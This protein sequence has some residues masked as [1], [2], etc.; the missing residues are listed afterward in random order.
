MIYLSRQ[1]CENIGERVFR[2]YEK[3]PDLRKSTIYRVNPE[4][5]VREVLKLKLEYHHLSLNGSV[6]G[7]TTPYNGIEYKIFD[8]EDKEDFYYFDG[9]TILIE[10]DLKEDVSKSGR[11]NFTT[12]HEAGHQILKMM[13]PKEYG[14]NYKKLHFCMAQPNRRTEKDWEEWQANNIGSVVIM[15][16]KLIG[17]AMFIF[18][19]GEKIEMINRI[20]ASEEYERFSGMAAF[21]GVSKK[22]LSIRLNQLGLV[23]RDYFDNPYALT[24][25]FFY[26]G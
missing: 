2:A 8:Y 15:P 10:R 4:L 13:F 22:A 1:D 17:Q 16:R 24:D 9:N 23:E 20:Y 5:L 11:C 14:G 3:L 26:G 7:V 19:F 6:L 12:A 18:G 25:V 21:L